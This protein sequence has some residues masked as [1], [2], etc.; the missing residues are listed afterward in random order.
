[1][2]YHREPPHSAL[3]S[4]FECE[5]RRRIFTQIYMF[6]VLISFSMGLPDLVRQVQSDIKTP[7]NLYDTDFGPTS[8]SLPPPRPLREISAVTYT[9]AK[10]R[11]VR[12][13]ARAA[14]ISHRVAPP[15]YTTVVALEDELEQVHVDIPEPLKFVPIELQISDPEALI[16]NR[17]KLELLYQ[18]TLCILHRRYLMAVATTENE[19]QSQDKCILAAMRILELFQALFGATAPAGGSLTKM[20]YFLNSLGSQDFL[21]AAMIICVALNRIEKIPEY[22]VTKPVSEMQLRTSLET[23]YEIFLIS[24][25]VFRPPERALKALEIMIGKK[26]PESTYR[27]RKRFCD[28]L[29]YFKLQT[30]L[31]KQ[32]A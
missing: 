26:S 16:F 20:P 8:T 18:K 3:V 13:F 10:W 5:M 32:I 6:D 4:P 17:F 7:S 25:L 19:C 12:V 31:L 21:L 15:N 9:V 27:P 29:T 22:E 11:I 14:D 2:G 28:A 30:I 1:M 23:T 24:R